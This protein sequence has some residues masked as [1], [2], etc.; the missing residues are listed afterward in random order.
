MKFDFRKACR[1]IK[2]HREQLIMMANCKIT[3]MQFVRILRAERNTIDTS[4]NEIKK[5]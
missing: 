1:W 3:C 2:N 4:I 5:N